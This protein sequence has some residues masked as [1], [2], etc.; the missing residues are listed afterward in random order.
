MDYLE[1]I[2]QWISDNERLLSGLA[3]LAFDNLSTDPEMQFFSDGI[4]D[5]I[6][7]RLS[8]GARL[9]VIGAPRAS[10][11][12]ASAS[13]RRPTATGQWPDCVDEVPYDL[14]AECARARDVP[15]A[16]FGP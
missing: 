2:Q 12:A 1:Q 4:S 3:V 16:T 9:R 11:F 5:E 10:S 15:K 8:R 7:Q 6:I 14:K 13:R